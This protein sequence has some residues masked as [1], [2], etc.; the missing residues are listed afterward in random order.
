M[1]RGGGRLGW[2]VSRAPSPPWWSAATRRHVVGDG[3]TGQHL[4]PTSSFHPAVGVGL[5]ATGFGAMSSARVSLGDV[6]SSILDAKLPSGPPILARRR[7]LEKKIDTAKAEERESV[8]VSRAKRAL[9]EQPHQKLRTPSSTSNAVREMELRKVATRGVVALFNAVRAAQREAD[10]ERGGGRKAK[11]RKE[12]TSDAH[13]T[14]G[15]AA[16]LSR[17]S[18]LD[19]LRRGT[20]APAKKSERAVGGAA[21]AQREEGAGRAS[22]LRDDFMLG[23]QRA[24]DFE[25]DLEDDEDY[26]EDAH[27]ADDDED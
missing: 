2:G 3:P 6:A 1:R 22:F 25:R 26:K 18:F 13:E 17:D 7:N 9:A 10:P 5:A 14:G 15:V 21:A 4:R 24:K 19:I 12:N 27:G 8:A 20:G 16:D 11:R 23:K